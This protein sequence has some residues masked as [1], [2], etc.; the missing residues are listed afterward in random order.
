MLS[1]ITAEKTGHVMKVLQE[2][3]LVLQSA[4]VPSVTFAA[5]LKY[6]GVFLFSVTLQPT[7]IV[8]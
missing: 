2:V 6:I 5:V 8:K 3:V 7:Y 1:K 4:G